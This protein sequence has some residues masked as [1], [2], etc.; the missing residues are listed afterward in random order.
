MLIVDARNYRVRR[1]AAGQVT[2]LAG[3]GPGLQ[4][5]PI[6]SA[7]FY[8]L[9]GVA[10]DGAGVYV[11]DTN[12]VRWIADGQVTTLAGTGLPAWTDGPAASAEFSGPRGLAHDGALGL[13]IADSGNSRIRELLGGMVTTLAGPALTDPSGVALASGTIYVADSGNNCVRR[14]VNGQVQ[15]LAGSGK[16]GFADGAAAVAMF[17]APLGVAVDPSGAVLVADTDNHSIRRIA[18]DVVTTVAGNGTP[19]YV[20]GPGALARFARPNDLVVDSSG[21][22]Y[23]ADG[24]NHCIR[25]IE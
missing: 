11:T 10:L 24:D 17:R 16:P 2:T 19:G 23:V 18:G 22:T 14:I 25:R 20:D 5:G 8:D 7:Q 1:I 13:I 9:W 4:D 3:T 6:E 21:V 15:T 12:C